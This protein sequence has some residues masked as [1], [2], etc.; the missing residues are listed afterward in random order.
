MHLWRDKLQISLSGRWQSFSLTAPNF[1]GAFPV[2]AGAAAISPPTAYTGDASA[3]YFFRSSGTKLR[4][5]IG[6]AYRSPSLY[7]RFGTYFDGSFFSAYGD[8]RLA[9]ERAISIDGGIDQYI[10]SKKIKLTASYFYTRLQNTIS[11][12]IT[13]GIVQP[14]TDPFG[15]F[16]GY[17]N[18]PGGI[19][20]GAE[21]GLEA[22]LPRRITLRAAY[23]FTNSIDRVSQYS[24]GVLQSPQVIPQQ[25]SFLVAKPFGKHWDTEVDGHFG[26]HYE[27]PFGGNS[28]PYNTIPLIFPAARQVNL[29]LGYTVPVRE[30]KRLR[31][32][33]RLD[34]L[35]DQ[36]YYEE[37]FVTPG[38]VAR[39]GVQFFF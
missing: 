38:F 3:A 34:N 24:D 9:P 26:N 10:G 5:H 6:N 7:E 17:Y 12:D 23:T 35:N 37:G 25:F 21:V 30:S 11:F 39:G 2:Y 14:F 4:T 22:A 13:G 29:S 31:I 32:Y 8:P 18:T 28:Y 36:T 27:Y 1:S 19:A 33:S 15:R 20:R 16:G